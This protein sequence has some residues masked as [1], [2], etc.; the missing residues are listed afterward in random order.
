M[1]YDNSRLQEVRSKISVP[2]YFYNVIIPQ[3]ADYYSD[4][5]VDFDA[6][7][8][9]KCPL[10]DE[11]TPS[12]RY[13]EE[14]NT[15]Y[16][17][18]CRAGGDV[19]ELHRR[20][21]ERMNDSKPSFEESIDFLYDF[22]VKGNANAKVIKKVGKLVSE[23]E[24]S[25][26]IDTVRYNRYFSLLETELLNDGSIGINIKKQLWS[27]MDA[28]DLLVSTNA[29]NAIDAMGYLKDKLKDIMKAGA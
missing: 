20:F 25:S 26:P 4:Y 5:P 27:I 2:M 6:R 11:D 15:F 18:G 23:E 9:C 3:R 21:T 13:Y 10:H 28:V 19:I 14:T 24:L 16:C 12:M 8:V 17:F 29:I 22:F 1:A 7:P